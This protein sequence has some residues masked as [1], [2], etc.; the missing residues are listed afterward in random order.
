M[1]VKK[2]LSTSDERYN[3]VKTRV[4]VARDETPQDPLHDWDQVFLFH[5]NCPDEMTG[6]ERDKDYEDPF[7]EIEDED[8]YGTGE[9]RFRDGIVWFPVAAYIHSGIALSL[10]SGSHFPDQ[11]W[12]VTRKFAYMWTDKKRFEK[13]CCTDGWMTVPVEKGSLKRRPAKDLDE[14]KDYLRGIAEGE[15]VTLQNAM[16]GDVYGYYT[17]KREE[18]KKVSPDGRE[19]DC[20][21]YIDGD[22]SCWGYYPDGSGYMYL[23]AP[24]SYGDD[25]EWFS[26]EEYLVGEK[27]QI[28]EF[29]V[30]KVVPKQGRYFLSQ[31][32]KDSAGTFNTMWTAKLGDAIVLPSWWQAQSV[33]QDV[34]DKDN[35]DAYK[36]CVEKDKILE[37]KEELHEQT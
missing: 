9:F 15:L 5:S 13:M 1:K 17:E 32:T 10:G 25:V 37:E 22:D 12:D 24:K 36:N 21:E 7:E 18:Y 28:P 33:A 6:N 31:Y 20:T 26:K 16:D 29:V 19:E 23:D 4:M 11:M 14:F 27:Y 34:I 30:T 3:T 35:Y 8:G 2:I